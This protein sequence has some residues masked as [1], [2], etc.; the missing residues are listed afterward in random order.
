MKLFNYL[1]I[2]GLLLGS[3]VLAEIDHSAHSATEHQ[4]V[5]KNKKSGDTKEVWYCPMHPQIQQSSPGTC[6]ICS[7]DLVMMEHEET[8]A[9]ETSADMLKGLATVKLSDWKQQLIA[10]KTE[11]VEKR[12]LNKSIN[13]VGRLGGGQGNF[14]A[15][16][17]AFTAQG[18]PGKRGARYVVA[19]IY[20]LD[21]PYLQKGQ[22]AV[23]T[24]F[25]ANSPAVSGRVDQL[26][27][28][29]GTQSRVM[30]ARVKL[31]DGMPD[32][33]FANVQIQVESSSKTAIPATAVIDTGKRRYVFVQI[34]PGKLVPKEVSLGFQGEDY[35]EVLSGVKQGDVVVVSA[36]FLID[37][38][39]QIKA[40]LHGLGANA[41]AHQ[42]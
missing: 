7:M 3:P 41:G 32:E 9:I 24:G 19:D 2:I 18:N 35:W 23:V 36:N 33:M 14:T 5:S 40:V 29:D 13:T 38:D 10:L 42:H 4:A 21:I 15:S 39:S 6:P 20:A 22:K 1:S 28:Y 31:N 30:R 26:Y 8:N 12:Q 25:G 27:P 11:K 16:A 17:S 37:A 34:E